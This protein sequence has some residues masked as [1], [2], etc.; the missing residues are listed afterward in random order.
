MCGL[1]G[2]V[3]R[4]PGGFSFNHLDLFEQFLIVD[5]LRGKD[6]TGV[7]SLFRNGDVR[8]IKHGSHPYNL[9][10]TDEWRDFKS[11]AVQRGKFLV[12]HNRKATIGKVNTD[13]AH[14]FVEE[15]IILVHN[16]T[17]RDQKNLTDANVEVDSHAIAHALSTTPYAEVIPKIRGAFALIWYDTKTEKLY[18]A[19]NEERPL[20]ILHSDDFYF[21]AS[22]AWMVGYPA[23]RERINITEAQN[24]N[25][26]DVA[27]FD[28]SGKLTIE[29][30]QLDDDISAEALQREYERWSHRSDRWDD[31]GGNT[32]P[33][34]PGTAETP[35]AEALRKMMVE[36][37]N[38]KFHHNGAIPRATTHS[39]SC[40]LTAKNDSA[41]EVMPNNEADLEAEVERLRQTI[42]RP[43]SEFP[44]GTPVLFK[45]HETTRQ[46]N[47]RFRFNGTVYTP[48]TPR[49]DVQGFLPFDVKPGNL[50]AW[51]D[52]QAY[53]EVQFCTYT[54]NGGWTI[55][56]KQVRLATETQIHSKKIPV[57]VW[58]YA[59]NHCTCSQCQRNVDYWEKT[60]CA[61]LQKTVIE[62]GCDRPMNRVH[63]V[64]PDCL[65]N[66]IQE[67]A[68]RVKFSTAYQ[69]AKS[70]IEKARAKVAADAEAN[71]D[72]TLP[73]RLTKQSESS[74]IN[75]KTLILPPP[76]AV[77]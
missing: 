28:S 55:H 71:S 51:H 39:S 31:D 43:H 48:D 41:I 67:G 59:K 68:Y 70:A 7:F 33:F 63:L 64:C 66:N 73:D 8:V 5:S 3:A 77:Q 18:A 34:V 76:S 16:G 50:Q 45:I 25:L 62:P 11:A 52:Q 56:L 13:N 60:F 72:P 12:G 53:G 54:T 1:V 10:R 20:V 27:V 75:G 29:T 4:K 46:V 6:S 14:P 26:G 9:F 42:T 22:E 65:K 32:V 2:M 44:K 38:Q 36:Q 58:D 24:L 35:S 57:M 40:V 74:P 23:R 17:L 61:V 49:L 69:Q 21:L 37:H 30:L 19:R 15:N 47:Q